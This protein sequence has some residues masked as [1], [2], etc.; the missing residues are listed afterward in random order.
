MVCNFFLPFCMLPFHFVDC[1]FSYAEGFGFDKIPLF[2]LLLEPSSSVASS[3]PS[4]YL[5]LTDEVSGKSNMKACC[6][7]VKHYL[8]IKGINKMKIMKKMDTR[9]FDFLYFLHLSRSGHD[10]PK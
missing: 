4:L 9:P 5:A 7:M 1:F 6:N 3:V 10:D 8:P 2:L